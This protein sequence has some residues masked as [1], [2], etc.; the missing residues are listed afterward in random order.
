MTLETEGGK[1]FEYNLPEDDSMC[2]AMDL[3]EILHEHS[4]IEEDETV[5]ILDRSEARLLDY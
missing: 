4:M 3:E 1:T 5:A 2:L